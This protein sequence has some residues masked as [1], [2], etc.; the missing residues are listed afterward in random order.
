MAPSSRSG[1]AGRLRPRRAPTCW[2]RRHA[3]VRC[4]M[5][6]SLLWTS[7][8]GARALRSPLA[9]PALPQA[10]P[11]HR[12][13]R[14][15]LPTRG[16]DSHPTRRPE[17]RAS[18]SAPLPGLSGHLIARRVTAA[19]AAQQHA[20]S[21]LASASHA[22]VAD[23]A[24]APAVCWLLCAAQA[25]AC[26]WLQSR[27]S[28]VQD[29]GPLKAAHTAEK[30]R[31]GAD[32]RAAP[33]ILG[34]AA[35]GCLPPGPQHAPGKAGAA[36]ASLLQ[37]CISAERAA[38]SRPASCMSTAT[39]QTHAHRPRMQHTGSAGSFSATYWQ[40]VH[41][42]LLDG[43]GC[44]HAARRLGG[45]TVVRWCGLAF[46]MRIGMGG[47]SARAEGG[48]RAR[49]VCGSA[50]GAGGLRSVRAL[51][52]RE[53]GRTPFLLLLGSKRALQRRPAPM[54]ACP[55][56]LAAFVLFAAHARRVASA[57]CQVSCF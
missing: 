42:M 8:S 53:L 15:H 2:P 51:C 34:D 7:L 20:D 38:A 35:G 48:R 1:R 40:A 27:Q 22:S 16:Q 32:G 29:A 43:H 4:G 55:H 46:R 23:K 45:R 19:V 18:P 17:R 56:H 14:A 25:C 52:D 12:A 21:P 13:A 49:A 3:H 54:P 9:L 57:A 36:R 47:L 41:S 10:D 39:S 31:C 6:M 28:L 30:Q 11:A 24:P 26:A 37:R 44:H 5:L 50:G 33:P